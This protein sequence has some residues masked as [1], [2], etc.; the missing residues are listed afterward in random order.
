MTAVLLYGAYVPIEEIERK[1]KHLSK[2]SASCLM[3]AN[4]AYGLHRLP[5]DL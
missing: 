1:S 3:F 5:S 4:S 2:E